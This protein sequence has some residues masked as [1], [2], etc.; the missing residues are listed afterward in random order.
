MGISGWRRSPSARH[1][2]PP[3]CP[4][5]R[6]HRKA[7]RP[8]LRPAQRP[9]QPTRPQL[10]PRPLVGRRADLSA[11]VEILFSTST[12]K[13]PAITGQGKNDLGTPAPTGP[14]PRYPELSPA[15]DL[16][17]PGHRRRR[18]WSARRGVARHLGQNP[19]YRLTR[20]HRRCRKAKPQRIGLI[21][22]KRS[23]LLALSF[24]VSR[25]WRDSRGTRR[26]C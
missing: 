4:R 14:Y 16:F 10:R 11:V 2:W 8:L 12:K 23:H 17:S 18:Q 7:Q 1:C 5:P 21:S 3:A 9:A 26:D 6:Q 20:H 25:H 15:S 19:A 13:G 22:D 24:V